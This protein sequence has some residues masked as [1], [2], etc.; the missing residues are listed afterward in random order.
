MSTP[1]PPRLLA[2]VCTAVSLCIV[3]WIAFGGGR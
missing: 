3:A 1:H 2:L